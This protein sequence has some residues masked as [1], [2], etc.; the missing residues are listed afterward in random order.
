MDGGAGKEGQS[1]ARGGGSLS[2]SPL[3]ARRLV[4][5]LTSSAPRLFGRSRESSVG[6]RRLEHPL[7]TS[8]FFSFFFSALL[9]CSLVD[10]FLLKLVLGLLGLDCPEDSFA[11]FA[12]LTVSYLRW[13]WSECYGL[14]R[15]R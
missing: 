2:L 14:P 5:C 15:G 4:S 11:S 7:S 13:A 9:F 8:L 10:R 1:D 3:A 12:S 6:R